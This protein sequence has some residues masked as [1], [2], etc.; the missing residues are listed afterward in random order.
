MEKISKKTI[1]SALILSII[2][3]FLIT[4]ITY[5]YFGR[6]INQNNI[7]V[8]TINNVSLVY[9]DNK[10][11]MRSGLIPSSRENV[12]KGISK[13]NDKCID[14][15]DENMCSIYEFTIINDSDITQVFSLNMTPSINTYGNFHYMLFEN[16]IND[17]SEDT[18]PVSESSDPLTETAITFNDLTKKININESVTYTLVFYIKNA[19]NDQTEM[20]ARKNFVAN[21]KVN[22]ITTGEYTSVNINN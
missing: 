13:E 7:G 21:I 4:G 8:N 20:D 9:K 14:I 3:I 15:Y 19:D 5:A 17:L 10:D 18:I 6:T 22:S 11:L 1:L 2:L 12:L 16:N